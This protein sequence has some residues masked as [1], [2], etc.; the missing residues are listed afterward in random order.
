MSAPR[1]TTTAALRVPT[2]LELRAPTLAAP[3]AP[4]LLELRAPISVKLRAMRTGAPQGTK[5][6]PLWSLRFL[7]CPLRSPSVALASTSR[8]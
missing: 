7:G 3:R 4:T 5:R 2:L 8:S 6:C 1:A